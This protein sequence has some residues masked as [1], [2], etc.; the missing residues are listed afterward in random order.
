[1]RRKR[2]RPTADESDDTNEDEDKSEAQATQPDTEIIQY[3]RT[4]REPTRAEIVEDMRGLPT[5]R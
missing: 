1:M 4:P 5:R 3:T 2:K